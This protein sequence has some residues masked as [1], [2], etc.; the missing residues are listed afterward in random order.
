[1]DQ[2]FNNKGMQELVTEHAHL[3]K[4]Q[5]EQLLDSKLLR[6]INRELD[7]A[8]KVNALNKLIIETTTTIM[9]SNCVSLHTYIPEKKGLELTAWQGFEDSTIQLL[10]WISSH[11]VSTYAL[12]MKEKR[13]IL[14]D[15]DHCEFLLNPK[16]LVTYRILGICSVLS[17]PLFSHSG[18]LLGVISTHWN[19][20]HEPSERDLSL[21]NVILRQSADLMEQIYTRAA[22]QEEKIWLIGQKEAFHAAMSR[23]PLELSLR[24]LVD[25]VILQ[26]KGRAKAAFYL[27]P[28]GSECFQCSE[29]IPEEYVQIIKAYPQEPHF[30]DKFLAMNK[31]KPI[32]TT[33]IELDPAWEDL[34][35]LARKHNCRAYWSFPVLT[36]E[37]RILG[38]LDIYFSEPQE[39]T[40]RELEM[41]QV[42]TNAAS[43]IIAFEYELV[44]KMQ[45]EINM[46]K[47]EQHLM[48]QVRLRDEFIAYASHEINSPL[49]CM[50]LYMGIIEQ[51]FLEKNTPFQME[52]LNK[53]KKQL[54]L[55]QAL[56]RDMLDTT[57]LEEGKLHL[58]RVT[59]NLNQLILEKVQ[60]MQLETKNY[61]FETQLTLEDEIE[62][63]KE[64]IGQVIVNLISNA[65]KYSPQGG[66]IFITSEKIDSVIQVTIRDYG[67][68]IPEEHLDNIFEPFYRVT[69]DNISGMGIGL[70]ICKDIINSHQ[71][72]L[73]VTSQVGVG[74]TFSFTIPRK[75]A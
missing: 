26:T 42:L 1:M 9:Q 18:E 56:I 17:S 43:I 53:L 63:D 40:K 65:I 45:T 3:N 36:A 15:I 27:L 48:A 2:T 31:G 62:A 61:Q 59:F 38:T 37:E 24:A 55:L 44:A 60:D 67:L 51:A 75:L 72:T 28:P 70:S 11:D 58:R 46:K 4:A 10:Q 71:G 5:A 47:S 8:E 49:T 52:I 64:R 50:T 33:D 25:T 73:N 41:A 39:P 22:L 34:R 20:V 29:G 21:M 66:K 35:P 74:S 14:V 54:E 13:S 12:A 6:L 23:K 69:N 19:T 30:V 16:L 68:G 32:I 57:R 7:E